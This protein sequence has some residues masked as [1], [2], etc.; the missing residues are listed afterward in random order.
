MADHGSSL[1]V[2]GYIIDRE[3][4]E[5]GFPAGGNGPCRCSSTCCE[6]GV[7]ADVTERDRILAHRGLITPHND[8]CAFLDRLG[9]CSL[10]VAATAAGMHMWA[11]KP[12]Y[13]VLYP[14]GVAGRVVLYDDVLHG[15]Q[16]CCSARQS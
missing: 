12:L 7:Y 11:L 4:F 9:R 3:L 10:Q 14:V 15:E 13:C 5:R 6:G 8:K 2:K 1:R 16:E